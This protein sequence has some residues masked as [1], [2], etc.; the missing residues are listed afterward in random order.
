[1]RI[2]KVIAAVAAF[3]SLALAR[4][5]FAQGD[6]GTANDSGS[7]V[8]YS[9]GTGVCYGYS[10]GIII[11]GSPEFVATVSGQ[12]D[13]L[14]QLFPDQM[15]RIDFQG[16]QGR[17][18]TIVETPGG[19]NQATAQDGSAASAQL[20]G[21][22]GSVLVAGAG[23]SV[24]VT[25]DPGLSPADCNAPS[26]A[27]LAHELIGHGLN[28]LEGTN[29]SAAALNGWD[30]PFG[31]NSPAVTAGAINVE[32]QNAM[33]VENVVRAYLGVGLRTDYVNG[34][35]PNGEEG[36]GV[37]SGITTDTVG[38]GDPADPITIDATSN[39]ASSSA[40]I[41]VGDTTLTAS[42]SDSGST[43]NITGP[44]GTLAAT[45]TD[46]FASLTS[47]DD[48]GSFDASWSDPVSTAAVVQPDDGSFDS[49][50]FDSS[51]GDFSGG[52]YSFDFGGD[53]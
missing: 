48:T 34:V 19:P 12:L 27:A 2:V 40:T 33:D 16:A 10:T 42:T 5:A 7:G 9:G 28:D 30:S 29:A 20:L 26:L 46:S 43:A 41:T 8:C 45:S 53:F 4:P 37:C 13:T 44:D 21:T 23:S 49:S 3:S 14:R 31:I 24:N 18:A 17:I 11:S 1:M 38:T 15:A 32:E 50:S 39:D 51:S 25:Y 35:L 6:G 52:D 22:D 47:T 36:T